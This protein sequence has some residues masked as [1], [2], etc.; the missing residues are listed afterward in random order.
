MKDP[1]DT[2]QRAYEVLGVRRDA[3]RD[4]INRAYA[5]LTREQPGRGAELRNAWDRLRR[6]VHRLEE[7]LWYYA[8]VELDTPET[9]VESGEEISLEPELPLLEVGLEFT[10]VAQGRYRRDFSGLEFREIKISH[11]SAYDTEVADLLPIVFDR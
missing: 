8:V 9:P 5:R 11:I 1:L 4:E 10:D 7:D 6:P 3:S 2:G